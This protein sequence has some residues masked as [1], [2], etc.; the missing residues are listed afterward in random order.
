MQRDY[1]NPSVLPYSFSVPKRRGEKVWIQPYLFLVVEVTDLRSSISSLRFV[2][3]PDVSR[4]CEVHTNTPWPLTCT[5]YTV[6]DKNP[7]DPFV[8]LPT[9]STYRHFLQPVSLEQDVICRSSERFN[10]WTYSGKRGARCTYSYR[11]PST[12]EKKERGGGDGNQLTSTP[13][14]WRRFSGCYVRRCPS[15]VLEKD[16]SFKGHQVVCK[17]SRK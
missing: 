6:T 13:V 7:R 1:E 17:E 15:R 16:L 9:L 5:Y 10:T 11:H 3:H 4:T 2:N 14:P 8:A 12:E